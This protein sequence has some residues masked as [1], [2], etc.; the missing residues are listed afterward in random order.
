MIDANS[1]TFGNAALKIPPDF[2]V[3][4]PS[5]RFTDGERRAFKSRERDPRTGLP[6][7]VSQWAER[8]RIVTGGSM[9]GRWKNENAPYAV[10]PMNCWTVPSIR[11][12]Y[13]CFAP[14]VVKTQIAFNCLGYSID[15]DPGS[16][17]YVMPDEKTTKRIARRRILPMIKASQRLAS[18]LSPRFDDTTTL[19]IRFVNGMDLM[20]AWAT[21][22]AE[23]SSEDVRYFI[24]DEV[25]KW[26]GYSGI[27]EKKEAHP[28][29]L[30][31]I[32]TN[33]YPHTKKILALSTPGA[34]PCLITELIHYEADEVRRYQVPCLVCGHEQIME[35]EDIIVL[36]KERDPRV[37]VRK[38]LAR[39][40]CKKCG[41]FW[42]DYMRDQSVLRGKWISGMFNDDESWQPAEPILRPISVAFHLPAWYS[43]FE[44]LSD[45]AAAR[46]RGEDDPKKRM[47]YVTQK[48]AEEY[49][50]IVTTKKEENILAEHKTTLPAGIV[51]EKAIALVATFDSH[52]WGYRFIVYAC[53]EDALGFTLQKIQHGHL[54]SLVDVETLVYHVRYPIENSTKTMGIW[55]AAIDTG[56]NK[57]GPNLNEQEKTMTDEIYEWLRKQPRGTIYGVKGA[58]HKQQH[59]VKVTVIDKLPHSNKPILG[60]LELRILDVDQFKVLFHWRLT[61]GTKTVKNPDGTEHIEFETQRILFDADTDNEFVRELLA[62]ELRITRTRRQEWVRIRSANH[63]LDC[64][65]YALALVDG[66]WQPSLK[67]LSKRVKEMESGPAVMKQQR[68]VRSK[69]VE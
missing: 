64:T 11:E 18:L 68:R 10:E 14:Q 17:M 42:D 36:K 7:T 46:I 41:I 51:P 48:R 59:R 31:K 25:S 58:S 16:A 27:A 9:P 52:T 6:L 3:L 67:L 65:V 35:D 34:A 29:Y 12:I 53:I 50:E 8:Y 39:Y 66:E 43:I 49:K 28:W 56:G 21:S 19:S 57:P 2:S 63:Y 47:V 30:G 4:P 40:V 23:I 20:M 45:V 13:L 60:G 62:E 55:H 1:Y 44:S 54:G 69:G 33:T 38:K 15:Q 24:G 5:I 61:R 32:R 22:V 26:P 37:V